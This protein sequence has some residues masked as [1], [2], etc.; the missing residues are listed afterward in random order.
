M[1]FKWFCILNRFSWRFSLLD[2]EFLNGN[3]FNMTTSNLSYTRFFFYFSWT[4]Y[5]K[6]II[7]KRFWTQKKMFGR[8]VLCYKK[9]I[10][11]SNVKKWILHAYK[12]YS[13]SSFFHF[14]LD[15]LLVEKKR[16]VLVSSWNWKTS[17]LN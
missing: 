7:K 4:A 6:E 15:I 12:C 11:S 10:T 5:R 1:K 17:F 13:Q 16:D 3:P 2:A 8:L 14:F 9:N